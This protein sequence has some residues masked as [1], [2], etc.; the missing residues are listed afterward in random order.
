[1]LID[2]AL[3]ASKKVFVP[4]VDDR[5]ANMTML[6]IETLEGLE[7][8]QPF[9]ILEPSD[10]H[11]DGRRRETLLQAD[12]PIDVLLI[13]GLGFDLEGG[14]LGRGGGYYDNMLQK[15]LDRNLEKGWPRP[16][17][18]ALAYGCQVLGEGLQVPRDAHDVLIDCL[19]TAEGMREFS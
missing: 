2:D 16:K 10:F 3:T 13:P 7:R 4:R 12:G 8:V 11:P 6:H 5:S 9:N 15:V 19:V 17:I 14:R 18:V 1:M